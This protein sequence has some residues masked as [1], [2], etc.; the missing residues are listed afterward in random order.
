M[1]S[2]FYFGYWP[3]AFICH[4]ELVSASHCEPFLVLLRGQ[5]L[6]QVQDDVGG[7]LLA[8]SLLGEGFAIYSPP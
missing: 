2:L 6:K 3:L 8:I 4:A 1:F 5:I 7:A